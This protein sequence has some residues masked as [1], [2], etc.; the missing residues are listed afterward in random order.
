MF[1]AVG[2]EGRRVQNL[3]DSE[4]KGE[5]MA[6]LRRAYPLLTVPEPVALYVPRWDHDPLFKGAFSVALPNY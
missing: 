5:I 4:V 2:E 1:T 6:K 3:S